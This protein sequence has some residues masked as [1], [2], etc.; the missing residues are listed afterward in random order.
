MIAV[1][2]FEYNKAMESRGR[3][4]KVRTGLCIKIPVSIEEMESQ[5]I[6]LK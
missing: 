3:R 6:L 2:Y 1:I 4:D 5:I